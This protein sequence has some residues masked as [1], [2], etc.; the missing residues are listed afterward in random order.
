MAKRVLRIRMKPVS[1]SLDR[2]IRDLKRFKRIDQEAFKALSLKVKKSTFKTTDEWL[3]NLEV[4]RKSIPE[5]CPNQ[6][7]ENQ[8]AIDVAPKTRRRRS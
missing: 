8:F 7:G 1:D 5:W 2:L 4:A 3:L 6:R